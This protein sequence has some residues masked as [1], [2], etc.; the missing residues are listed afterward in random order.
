MKK[1]FYPI[2]ALALIAASAFTVVKSQD[3]KIADGY[4]VTFSSSDTKGEFKGLKG[5]ISFD[6]ANLKTSKFDCNIDIATI[7]TGNAMKNTHAKSADWFD[8]D[9]YPTIEF[10][11]TAI[12]KTAAGYEAAGTL[13]MHG[14]TKPTTIPFTFDGSTFKGSVEVARVDYG[15]N[16][17]QPDRGGSKFKVDINVPVTK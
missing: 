14:V 13:T 6:P 1:F 11:S 7:N 5:T 4:S 9:K 10:K 15:V 8:A 17:A 16:V 2:A 12:T 3:W